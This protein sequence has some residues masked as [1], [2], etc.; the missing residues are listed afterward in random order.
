MWH[1][2]RCFLQIR[3]S[4]LITR[5]V[6]RLARIPICSSNLSHT[7]RRFCHRNRIWTHILGEKRRN[8]NSA[9]ISLQWVGNIWC[10]QLGV[11]IFS[12]GN[13]ADL[14]IQ[15]ARIGS[16]T[17]TQSR[18]LRDFK[19]ALINSCFT[20]KYF[21]RL[22]AQMSFLIHFGCVGLFV[23]ISRIYAN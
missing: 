5:R 8:A 12:D 17:K 3:R 14:E 10:Y 4:C 20:D 11:W 15:L 2:W 6:I 21:D 16:V 19:L 18:S 13:L 23:F 9:C 22:W 7:T 1:I